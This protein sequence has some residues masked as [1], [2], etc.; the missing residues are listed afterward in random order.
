M[1]LRMERCAR[2]REVARFLELDRRFHL[3]IL[4]VL[5]NP[6]L[7]DIV[8]NLRAQT[9]VYR[10]HEVVKAGELEETAKAHWGIFNAIRARDGE[11]AIALMRQHL[12][13]AC[14]FWKGSNE[15]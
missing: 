10:L 1:L 6:R 15:G 11:K 4:S 13:H 3:R 14:K 9:R 2:E 5:G 8:D 12:D 7:T